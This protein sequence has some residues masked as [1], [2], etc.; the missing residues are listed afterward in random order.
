MSWYLILYV[1]LTILA[2]FLVFFIC[3]ALL[4]LSRTLES[5]NSM[6]IDVQAEVTPLLSELRVTIDQV[7]SELETVDDVVQSVQEIGDK[8]TAT[9]TVVQEII[10]SPLIKV[11]SLSAGAKEAIGVLLKR[12]RK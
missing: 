1:V 10:S 3:M 5:L 8:V 6:I 4:R 9:A 7:N 2:A 11:A 12:R